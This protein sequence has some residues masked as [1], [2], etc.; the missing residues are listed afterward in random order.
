MS[1]GTK[2]TKSIFGCA[3]ILFKGGALNKEVMDYLQLSAET[4]RRIKKAE[5]YEEY[6]Q[7]NSSLSGA[8]YRKRKA[9]EAKVKE[10]DKINEAKQEEKKEYVQPAAQVVEHRQSVTIQATHFMET[11]LDILIE[12]MKLLNAKV[13]AVIDD[14]YGVGSGKGG[15]SA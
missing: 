11:K 6:F 4:V 15:A 3:K 5:T 10:A 14:L 13:G 8:G 2:V 9:A 1:N 7:I 12:Q